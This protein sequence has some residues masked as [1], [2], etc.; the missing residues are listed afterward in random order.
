MSDGS[1]MLAPTNQVGT[2]PAHVCVS[3]NSP[4]VHFMSLRFHMFS[5]QQEDYYLMVGNK[6]QA[7]LKVYT[8]PKIFSFVLVYLPAPCLLYPHKEQSTPVTDGCCLSPTKIESILFFACFPPRKAFQSRQSSV[9]A[10][11]T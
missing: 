6:T 9:K 2:F 10:C 8:F 4:N 1:H 7:L 11:V 3:E 5:L